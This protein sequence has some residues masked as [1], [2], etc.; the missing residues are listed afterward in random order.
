ME[1]VPSNAPGEFVPTGFPDG[2]YALDCHHGSEGVQAT[3]RKTGT[4]L[5]GG[6][7]GFECTGVLFG[8]GEA[9]TLRLEVHQTGLEARAVFGPLDDLTF[10]F[11]GAAIANGAHLHGESVEEPRRALELAIRSLGS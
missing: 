4:N 11:V 8:L 1:Q 3:V 7:H 6:G 9:R 2:L 10:E 5:L